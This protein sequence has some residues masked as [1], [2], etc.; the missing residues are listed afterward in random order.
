MLKEWT[1]TVAILRHMSLVVSV[2]W[3]CFV[4][5]A[6]MVQ[7][8][9]ASCIT[10]TIRISSP[11][12]RWP[13]KRL[14]IQTVTISTVA[15]VTVG[16]WWEVSLWF[17]QYN[18]DTFPFSHMLKTRA[19]TGYVFPVG[20]RQYCTYTKRAIFVAKLQTSFFTSSLWLWHT[21]ERWHCY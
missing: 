16:P 1:E 15:E 19:I 13:S 21:W 9:T 5:I 20:T 8:P 17:T 10:E 14:S 6:N 18:E 3:S 12:W 11:P 4:F 7:I 2:L